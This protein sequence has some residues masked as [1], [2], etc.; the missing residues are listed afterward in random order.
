VNARSQ[1]FLVLA[2]LKHRGPLTSLD[3]LR[4]LGCS[5]LAARCHELKAMGHKIRRDLVMVKTRNGKA[6]VARYSIGERA[7]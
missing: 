5:R 2:H 4:R 6:R 7:A 3:A 1:N